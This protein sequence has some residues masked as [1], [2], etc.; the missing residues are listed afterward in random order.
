M[1]E[2]GRENKNLLRKS[3]ESYPGLGEKFNIFW[4]GGRGQKKYNKRKGPRQ[5]DWKDLLGG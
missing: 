2:D 1:R 5:K 4:E 3:L